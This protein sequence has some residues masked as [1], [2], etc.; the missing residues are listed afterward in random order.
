[1]TEWFIGKEKF[2]EWYQG[3]FPKL[4]EWYQ[5]A[6]PKLGGTQR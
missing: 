5:G 2:L 3:A 4:L 1:L 6:F